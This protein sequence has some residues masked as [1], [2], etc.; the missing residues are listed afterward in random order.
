MG[1]V[2][3]HFAHADDD[4]SW[5]W[6]AIRRWYKEFMAR[7]KQDANYK[8]DKMRCYGHRLNFASELM[9]ALGEKCPPS[10]APVSNLNDY[11]IRRFAQ[12]GSTFSFQVDIKNLSKEEFGNL[13]FALCL[14]YS[15]KNFLHKIGKCKA[16]GLGSCRIR[17]ECYEQVNFIERYSSLDDDGVEVYEEEYLEKLMQQLAP[18]RATKPIAQ[19]C[20]V[21]P[22]A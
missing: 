13:L 3:F 1:R 19:L 6:Y 7:Q 20:Q 5:R 4:V 22:R 17:L 2:V 21:L 11:D 10:L 14:D 18:V 16:V 8:Y 9:I 12:P 15:G